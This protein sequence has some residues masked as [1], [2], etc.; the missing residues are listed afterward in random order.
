MECLSELAGRYIAGS[1]KSMGPTP[2]VEAPLTPDGPDAGDV[3][4][5]VVRIWPGDGSAECVGFFGVLT[6]LRGNWRCGHNSR[7]VDLIIGTGTIDFRFT[8]Q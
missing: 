2:G 5:R 8:H 3:V 7:A 1:G 4:D 6:G